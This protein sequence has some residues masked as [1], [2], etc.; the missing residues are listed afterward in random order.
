MKSSVFERRPASGRD[1]AAADAEAAPGGHRGRRRWIAGGAV[2]VVAAA[3]VA[4]AATDPFRARASSNAGVSYS[5]STWTVTRQSL[6]EQTLQDA[7]LGD[8]GS[9]SV[10]NQAQGSSGGSG[11]SGPGGSGSSTGP[12]GG[13]GSGSGTYT[14]L[15]AAGA[16]V[17]QGQVLYAVSGTPVVLLYGATPAYRDL[18]EGDTGA[19]VTELN[20]DL[21]T[22]G[23]LTAAE[24]GSRS[25]WD[26]YSAETA[27]GVEQLQ[28]RLGVT[29]TGSLDLGAAVFLPSA[30]EVTG[31][32]SSVVLGGP[33]STGQVVLTAS[34]TTPQVTIDLD[35]SLQGEMHAGE[36]V[37]VTLPDGSDT[38]GVVSSVSTV[39]TSSSPGGSGGSGSGGSG[40]S[41]PGGSGSSAT[42][43]VEVS[44][45][46]PAAAGSLN[47][48]PVEVTI[49]TGSV[50]N[51]LVVPVDAL[52][53]QPSGSY[54]VEVIGA[55]GRHYLVPVT[56][57]VFDDA[58]GLVQVTGNLTPGQ[59][60]VVPGI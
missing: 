17:R 42:V 13:A 3:A 39:A 45:D 23:Y 60:V 20:T 1:G 10:V 33:A 43:T 53:A 30:I 50:S 24:L 40:G 27:Y 19:D 8:A 9:Y 37:S 26:Y 49:T 2:V 25:G 54:A 51:A 38:P 35:A 57:G 56:P 55:G 16:V 28:A 44:L 14:S 5:T 15:P 4:L 7:T 31:L 41:G 59:K 29:Q 34:S 32:G 12:G 6:T 48:A 46:D 22:L 58:A 52:L 36:P 47:Q 21:V 18:A 11:S